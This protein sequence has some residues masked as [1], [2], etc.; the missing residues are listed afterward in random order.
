MTHIHAPGKRKKV[1]MEPE[2][3]QQLSF[4]DEDIA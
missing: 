2:D 4:M 3:I 1:E